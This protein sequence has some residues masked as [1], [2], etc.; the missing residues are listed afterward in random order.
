MTATRYP[1]S[2]DA[3]ERPDGSQPKES[4]RDTW[5]WALW[6]VGVLLAA[7]VFL[8]VLPGVA[9]IWR[10]LG[11]LRAR[12]ADVERAQTAGAEIVR[13][14]AE[15]ER[16]EQALAVSLG[17]E[18]AQSSATAVG[19]L[20]ALRQSAAQAGVRVIR[21]E[22]DDDEVEVRVEGDGHA[23]GRFVDELERG[24]RLARVQTLAVRGPGTRANAQTEATL[25]V[26]FAEIG[27]VT[28]SP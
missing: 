20:G 1:S 9:G 10:D 7:V 6:G 25:I 8:E 22:P 12:E 26:E 23:V 21:V 5:R 18:G 16:L 28:A 14:D 3:S 4:G 2:P 15:G 11:T 13:L 17:V 19:P 24:A 27:S